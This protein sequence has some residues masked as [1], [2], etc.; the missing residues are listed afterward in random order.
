MPSRDRFLFNRFFDPFVIPEE[1]FSPLFCVR[2]FG[3]AD[4]DIA[5]PHR[6][7]VILQPDWQTIGMLVVLG[8]TVERSVAAQL[9]VIQD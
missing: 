8:G 5:K 7:S 9:E 1:G 3:F 4:P 6:I 2:G